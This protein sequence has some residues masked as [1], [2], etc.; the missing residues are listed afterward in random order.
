MPPRVMGQMIG[1]STPIK[2]HVPSMFV[3]QRHVERFGFGQVPMHFFL[4]ETA[5]V[6][7][8]VGRPLMEPVNKG[9]VHDPRFFPEF[10]AHGRFVSRIAG[11]NVAF[12]KIPVALRVL[13]QK[14]GAEVDQHH[15]ARG[16]HGASTRQVLM[17]FAPPTAR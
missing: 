1:C 4:D 5:F 10:A 9:D 11:L 6:R 13:E 12:R 17:A 8:F 7:V 3:G 14:H 15:A 16:L 2:P